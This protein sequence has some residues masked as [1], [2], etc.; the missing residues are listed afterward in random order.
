M[1][2]IKLFKAFCIV[3]TAGT[4]CII[5][6]NLMEA[7]K[8]DNTRQT[9]STTLQTAS[10][11][12]KVNVNK[13]DVRQKNKGNPVITTNFT[14]EEQKSLL[15]NIKNMELSKRKVF[16]ITRTS[17]YAVLLIFTGKSYIMNMEV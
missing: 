6:A 13:A 15:K 11:V 8:A 5:P 16:Y 7:S 2:K 9:A 4:I 12:N 1:R 17:L 14:E 10:N 3:L